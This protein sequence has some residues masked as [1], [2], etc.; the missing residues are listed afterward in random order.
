MSENK[1]TTEKYMTVSQAGRDRE[2]G[3]P[4]GFRPCQPNGRDCR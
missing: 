2:R 4:D 3:S 1:K